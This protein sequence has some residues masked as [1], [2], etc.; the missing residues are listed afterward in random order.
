MYSQTTR[1]RSAS[2]GRY[3]R[4]DPV[5]RV[6]EMLVTWAA[7][8]TI[9]YQ[10]SEGQGFSI[11]LLQEY[12]GLPPHSLI[13]KGVEFTT[14]EDIEVEN[15]LMQATEKIQENTI[16]FYVDKK[17]VSKYLHNQLL[18]NARRYLFS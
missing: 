17:P 15:W 16:R 6:H 1:R 7:H 2:T 14:P 5:Q 4:R 8:I 13:P 11:G 12:S 3:M 9:R 10:S 18:E